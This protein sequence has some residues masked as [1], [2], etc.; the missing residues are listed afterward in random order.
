MPGATVAAL[1]LRRAI[2]RT[3]GAIGVFPAMRPLQRRSWSVSAWETDADL[4]C[5]LHSP[6]HR[7]TVRRYRRHL[8]VRSET[9]RVETFNPPDALR[10]AAARFA[11]VA[12][13]GH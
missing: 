5:F 7:A 4:R 3:P 13:G 11:R 6:A 1:R 10:E 9:W 8:T 12:A 2:R